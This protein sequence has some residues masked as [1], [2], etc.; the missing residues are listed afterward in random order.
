K[1]MKG[2]DKEETAIFLISA[3]LHT[4]YIYSKALDYIKNN[5]KI[6]D[7]DVEEI[8][9]QGALQ[10]MTQMGWGIHAIP[11]LQK[12]EVIMHLEN[13]IRSIFTTA[14]QRGV[15]TMFDAGM[16]SDMASMLETYRL[17]NPHNIRV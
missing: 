3:S 13:N 8:K 6:S 10:E 4:A 2:T 16:K 7:A 5:N 11:E 14:N 12:L 15:T 1:A 9:K 17:Y